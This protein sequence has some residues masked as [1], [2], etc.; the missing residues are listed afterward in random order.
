MG[1]QRGEGHCPLA[2]QARKTVTQ[3]FI[4]LPRHE[5]AYK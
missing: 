4:L 5:L 2:L 1:E 3:L